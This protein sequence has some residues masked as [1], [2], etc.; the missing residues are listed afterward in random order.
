MLLL[1]LLGKI[2]EQKRLKQQEGAWSNQ[3]P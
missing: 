3:Q 2:Q 1:L